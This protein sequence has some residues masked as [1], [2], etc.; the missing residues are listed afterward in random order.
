MNDYLTYR[1]Q[2]EEN[3]HNH[4]QSYT[5]DQPMEYRGTDTEHLQSQDIRKTNNVKQP[6]LS[7]PSR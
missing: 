6:A 2:N 5:T 3:Y 4:T 1:A 7:S